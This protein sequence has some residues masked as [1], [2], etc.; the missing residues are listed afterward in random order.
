MIGEVRGSSQA[1]ELWL[2]DM[3]L[4][5]HRKLSDGNHLKMDMDRRVN[6][7]LYLESGLQTLE[8]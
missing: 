7:V 6:G 4:N 5:R 8:S 2:R 3:H 1:F